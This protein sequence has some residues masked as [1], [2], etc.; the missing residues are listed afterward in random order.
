MEA[1]KNLSKHE[2]EEEAHFDRIRWLEGQLAKARLMT[3][4]QNHLVKEALKKQQKTS[5]LPR[6]DP[7]RSRKCQ[8]A[9]RV[10]NASFRGQGLAGFRFFEIREVLDKGEGLRGV[11][12]ALLGEGGTTRGMVHAEKLELVLNRSKGN[13]K[14]LFRGAQRFG[15]QGVETL[16]DPWEVV[17]EPREPKIMSLELGGL[18][19]LGGSWPSAPAPRRK[20]PE[21]LENRILWANRLNAFLRRAFPKAGL[22]VH[23][24]DRAED[25]SFYGLDLLGY[26][27]KGVLKSRYHAKRLE[28][29]T[30][31]DSN[32]VELRFFD[33]FFQDAGGKL[34]FPAAGFQLVSPTLGRKKAERFLAG[35]C[36]RYRSGG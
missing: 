27:E 24:L 15:R 30:D 29:W 1:E 2:A 17:L 8:E 9:V 12:L 22:R 6:Q 19:Q 7:L 35:F 3:Q 28:I 14:M 23:H 26:T 33:G 21:D 31:L 5:P 36:R 32:R 20:K 18:C 11:D 25:L 16:A 34:V 10:L 4:T 13:L